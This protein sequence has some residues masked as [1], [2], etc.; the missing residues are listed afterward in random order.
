MIGRVRTAVAAVA[1]CTVTFCAAPAWTASIY[2]M[3]FLGERME[4]GDVRAIALGG[5]TQLTLDSLAVNHINTALLARLKKVT[6]GATQYAAWDEGRSAEYQEKDVSAAFASFRAAFPITPFLTIAAGYFGRYDADGTFEVPDET[7]TGDAFVT[8]F[9]RSGGLFSIPLTAA[10]NL[11]R[12]ASVGFT[13]SLERGFLEDR[14]DID[15]E[16]RGRV[17]GAGFKKE[18]FSGTGYALS[19]AFYPWQRFVLGASF[20]SAIDY[21]TDIRELYTQS[22]L[23]TSYAA[24]AKLPARV[25]AGVT[26]RL[27]RRITL[28]GSAHWSDFTKFHGLAFPTELLDT[29]QSY[30]FG[31]E[32]TGVPIFGWRAPIR[33]SFQWERLPFEFPPGESVS[34]YLVGLGTG[35]LIGDGKGK[36]D[37]AVR[38][39]AT[40][41]AG[42]NGLED[43]LFRVYVGLTGSEVWKRKGVRDS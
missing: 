33:T 41:S 20:E 22:V 14:W 13:F 18:E 2:S 38:V 36:V 43:R 31:L 29:E 19:A 10:F 39:G 12:H 34:R 11:T 28:L 24:T 32:V 37:I 1:L 40:G 16:E 4:S 42:T 26:L 15:F 5:S 7:S 27:T 3:P 23:D 9:I 21:D 25:S 17:P 30:A 8:R 6:L 35:I